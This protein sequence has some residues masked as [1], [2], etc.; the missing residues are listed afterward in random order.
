MQQVISQPANAGEPERQ[1]QQEP[2]DHMGTVLQGTVARQELHI[3]GVV[4]RDHRTHARFKL[5]SLHAL[6]LERL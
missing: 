6:F 4:L 5:V 1:A 2:R 3:L